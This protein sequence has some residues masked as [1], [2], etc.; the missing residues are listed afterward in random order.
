[1]REYSMPALAE[2]PAS[3]NLADI[4]GRRAAEQPQAV[5]LRRKDGLMCTATRTEA[6]A[7]LAEGWI[8]HRLQHLQQR[9]L[10]EPILYR[11][12]AKFALASVRLRNHDP[13]HRLRPVGP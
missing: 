4:V 6:I 2:V 10:D 8:K 1:M 13:S 5:M 3:A 7:V 9:L 11:R 12:D